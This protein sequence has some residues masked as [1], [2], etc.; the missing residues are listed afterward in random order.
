VGAN[1]GSFAFGGHWWVGAKYNLHGTSDFDGRIFAIGQIDKI[2]LIK[3]SWHLA[4]LGTSEYPQSRS[5]RGEH[6]LQKP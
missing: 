6:G 4:T 1:V 5:S 3:L 2:D